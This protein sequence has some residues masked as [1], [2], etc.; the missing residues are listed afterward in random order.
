VAL[1]GVPDEA[2][3]EVPVAVVKTESG[4]TLDTEQVQDYLTDKVAGFKI[5]RRVEL[6][7]D[8]PMTESGKIQKFKL[9]EQLSDEEPL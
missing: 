4:S 1:V 5:P 9:K 8:F 6:V 2:Y 7:D 3:G